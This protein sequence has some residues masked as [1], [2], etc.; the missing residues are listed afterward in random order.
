MKYTLT[1]YRDGK[2]LENIDFEGEG[3]MFFCLIAGGNRLD[4]GRCDEY[5]ITNEKG[6]VVAYAMT[7]DSPKAIQANSE[8]AQSRKEA[9]SDRMADIAREEQARE[10]ASRQAQ[11]GVRI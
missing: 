7:E 10:L 9:Q 11:R 6:D 5:E 2:A 3:K 8:R 1:T 4:D